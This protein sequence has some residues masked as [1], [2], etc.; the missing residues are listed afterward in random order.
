MSLKL[1]QKDLYK[2]AQAKGWY[3]KEVTFPDIVMRSILELAEAIEAYNIGKDF[4]YEENG[5][6]E[7]IAVEIVDTIIPLLH[8]L[9]HHG[10]DADYVISRKNEYNK[11]RAHRHG[12]KK[13]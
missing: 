1:I 12:N 4:Y 3:D 9:E 7:G 10:I 11:G 6:P 13:F 8:F 5:K 2:T